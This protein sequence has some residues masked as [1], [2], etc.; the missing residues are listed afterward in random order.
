[1]QYNPEFEKR[2]A[3][4]GENLSD[5]YS[6]RT[7]KCVRINTLKISVDDFP[8]K[9]LEPVPWCDSAFFFDAPSLSVRALQ[10]K[11]LL[12]I[13]DAASLI[14]PI[15][16]DPEIGDIVLDMC[17]APGT[18]TLHLAALLDNRGMLFAC[19][20]GKRVLRLKSNILDYGVNCNVL[21]KNALDI[22]GSADK[23]LLDAPCSGEGI[24]NKIHKTMPMW[25]E[26]RVLALSILQRRLL[27]KAFELLNENG[28]IVYST[29]T[30]EIEENEKVIESLLEKHE[31]AVLEKISIKGL[32]AKAGLTENTKKCLRIYPYMHRT[33]GF[34]VA[35]IK[36]E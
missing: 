24:V 25:S 32:K 9:G 15:A 3:L 17:A 21:V 22:E 18:K 14:P 7:R 33:N 16:L 19:D 35:K 36:K 5:I 34:F 11:R 27:E 26:K 2:I 28:V 23:I 20:F 13:Q 31:N 4:L 8:I 10:K 30:F 1:M 29:C 6:S 12:Y